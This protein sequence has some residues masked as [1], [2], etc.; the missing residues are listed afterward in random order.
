MSGDMVRRK[1]V[2]KE[3]RERAVT[4]R[5]IGK[6]WQQ[7]ADE[8]GYASPGAAYK[9]VQD[10]FTEYPS[11]DVEALRTQE[12]LKLD[13][14][15]QEYWTIIAKGHPVVS[16]KGIVTRYI[17]DANG[18]RKNLRDETGE[19]VYYQRG[20]ENVPVYETEEL[21]DDD[22]TIKALHGL[23]AVYTRRAKLNGLDMPTKLEIDNGEVDK[24]IV[25]LVEAMVV[26]GEPQIPLGHDG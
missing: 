1:T 10:Y 20:D 24:E 12:N 8:V 18:R 19:F 22:P 23:V 17:L 5:T 25:E 3:K 6:T 7:I 2:A 14:V 21:D 16:A 26:S 11:P 9:A 13:Q 15:E 4:L